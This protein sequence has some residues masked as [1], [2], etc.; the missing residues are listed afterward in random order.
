MA[1]VLISFFFLASSMQLVNIKK[2]EGIEELLREKS[3]LVKEDPQT[4]NIFFSPRSPFYEEVALVYGLRASF[5]NTLI[6]TIPILSNQYEKIRNFKD[7]FK[8]V[9][10][11]SLELGEEKVAAGVL[12][13]FLAK[14]FRFITVNYKRFELRQ[15]P[16]HPVKNL[17]LRTAIYTRK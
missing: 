13:A 11:I 8:N 2:E 14:D 15:S 9:N 16:F 1:R 4:L 17:P 7:K 6:F 12:E 5:N 10:I 3:T